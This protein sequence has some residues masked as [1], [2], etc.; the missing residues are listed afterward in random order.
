MRME[1][2]K[3][4]QVMDKRGGVKSLQLLNVGD[5]QS[6][7]GGTATEIRHPKMEYNSE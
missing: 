4:N 2:R 5:P 6:Q 3:L 1:G 7:V